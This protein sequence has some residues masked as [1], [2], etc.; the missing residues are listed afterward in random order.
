MREEPEEGSDRRSNPPPKASM[1][2]RVGAGALAAGLAASF[3]YLA[4]IV[5]RRCAALPAF[6]VLLQP[7]RASLCLSCA[8]LTALPSLLSS[9][10]PPGPPH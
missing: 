10:R 1:A 3:V 4:F 8:P 5:P 6:A 2:K 7:T 9:R